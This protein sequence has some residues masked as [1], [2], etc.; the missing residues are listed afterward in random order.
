MQLIKITAINTKSGVNSRGQWTKYSITGENN[1]QFSTFDD[2]AHILNIGDTIEAE[3]KMDGKYANIMAF[4]KVD[5]MPSTQATTQKQAPQP[6]GKYNP[7]PQPISG[8][9]KGM[10]LKEIGDNFRV[11]LFTKGDHADLWNYYLSEISRITGVK[12]N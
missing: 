5:G 2:N 7:P 10:I 6:S 8:P 3:V 9:E 4:R 11:K 1:T 12:V